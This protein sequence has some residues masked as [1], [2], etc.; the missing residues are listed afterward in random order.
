MIDI[1]WGEKLT[2]YIVC[3]FKL[4]I[5]VELVIIHRETKLEKIHSKIFKV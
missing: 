3:L 2:K 5:M 1:C 4:D